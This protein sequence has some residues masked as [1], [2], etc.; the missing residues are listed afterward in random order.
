MKLS[1]TDKFLWDIYKNIESLDRAYD[2]FA[3][4]TWSEA[5]SPHLLYSARPRRECARQRDRERFRQLVYYLRKKGYI[6]TVGIEHGSGVM[7]TPKG[8]E[9]VL[10]I[11]LKE[12]HRAR[13]HDKK[14]QMIIFDIPESRRRQR[15]S[16]RTMLV[17]MGYRKLQDSVW[18]CPF[19][20][21]KETEGMID[22]YDLREYVQLFLIEEIDT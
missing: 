14:W 18:V 6:K 20:V 15:D 13:R 17:E 7:L 2:I 22:V 9:R 11:V 3:R 12:G 16:L 4:R 19:D 8:S 21:V 10:K 5:M 1:I